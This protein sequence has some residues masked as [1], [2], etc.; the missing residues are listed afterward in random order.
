MQ[1][2]RRM[3]FGATLVAAALAWAAELPSQVGIGVEQAQRM[4]LDGIQS[5][6]VYPGAARTALRAATPAQRAAWVD[7]TLGWVKAY[8]AS[9]EFAAA[10]ARSRDD[11]R[12]Q[13]PP[14]PERSVDDELRARRAEMEQQFEQGRKNAATLPA[15]QRAAVE[16]GLAQ[17]REA[18]AAMEKDPQMAQMQRQVLEAERTQRVQA[19]EQAMSDW[20]QTHPAGPKVRIKQRLEEFLALS[21]TVDFQAATKADGNTLRFVDPE[22]ERKPPNWK[23]C[24]RAGQPAVDAARAFATAWVKEL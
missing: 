24:Y 12:P 13:P 18:M 10:Y 23:L 6:T 21:A 15:E 9:P 1:H 19:F 17:A 16:A 7:A 5:G 8:T 20:E 2:M 22:L 14:T 4:V 3:A 11:S